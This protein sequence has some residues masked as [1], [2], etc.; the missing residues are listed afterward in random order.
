LE[1]AAQS[2]YAYWLLQHQG[3]H[4]VPPPTADQRRRMALREARRHV[5]KAGYIK[6]QKNLPNTL[7]FRSVLEP[8]HHIRAA[9]WSSNTDSNSTTVL[10]NGGDGGTPC[11]TGSSSNIVY[12]ND[13]EKVAIEQCRAR[14]ERDLKHQLGVVRGQDIEGH[15]VLIY[16][17][18]ATAAIDD[19]SFVWS[20][21]YLMERALATT[22]Y[23]SMGRLEKISVVLDFGNFAASLAPS[24]N[25]MQRATTSLQY[26]Y[27]ERL[28]R[29]IIIDPPFWMRTTYNMLKPFLDP[30]TKLKFIMVS[31]DQQ[32]IE[33]LKQVIPE[34]HAMPFML[35]GGMLTDP[36]DGS[37][38]FN[39]VP[40]HCLYDHDK[41]S[42]NPA[43]SN[44]ESNGDSKTTVLS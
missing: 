1:C 26:Y 19:D 2:S 27:P 5:C 25:A 21:L 34:S 32:K 15:A 24:W 4:E 3:E 40:F 36:V 38:F 6:A 13:L 17:S 14:I 7:Q 28:K 42:N 43:V 41:E 33:C 30:E 18:R 44:L 39:E 8:I 20:L 37:K 31:G 9:A 11:T 35:P 12:E 10:T 16:Y 29:L 23:T 22:E